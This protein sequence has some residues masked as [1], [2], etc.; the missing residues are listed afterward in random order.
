[1]KKLRQVLCL[2][3]LCGTLISACL[4]N[5]SSEQQNDTV[6]LLDSNS[7][8]VL[9]IAMGGYLSCPSGNIYRATHRHQMNNLENH[10]LN[11]GIDFKG[12]SSC[13]DVSMDLPDTVQ[14]HYTLSDG[15]VYYS[16][17][18]TFM[19]RILDEISRYPN[20]DVY[21]MGHSHGGWLSMKFLA[22]VQ[23]PRQIKYYV[24]V[25]PISRGECPPM[26]Y[27]R[28]TSRLVLNPELNPCIRFP[29]D[30][31]E[32]ELKTINL[33]TEL[34]DNYYQRA[35][36]KLMSNAT[37][38]ANNVQVLY[39]IERLLKPLPNSA[40]FRI[41][42]DSEVWDNLKSKILTVGNGSQ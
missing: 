25:D 34:W 16:G 9:V 24:S 5:E 38:A 40:H 10:I 29:R 32:N 22:N 14:I 20:Y 37:E 18:E 21:M 28:T 1:M 4:D 30:I 23:L 31:S 42:T 27:L 35:T 8:G 6:A 13:Y 26:V 2:T 11:A 41:W 33:Q 36:Q 7:K 39:P 19:K 3:I 15:T 12:I 17:L